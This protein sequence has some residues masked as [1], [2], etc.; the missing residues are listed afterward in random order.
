MAREAAK[1]AHVMI[2]KIFFMV[3]VLGVTYKAGSPAR[4]DKK[5]KYA[6]KTKKTNSYFHPPP[7]AR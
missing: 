1:R 7:S 2:V 6:S 5:Q 4:N 3:L